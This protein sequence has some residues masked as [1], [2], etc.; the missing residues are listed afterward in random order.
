MRIELQLK[1]DD[2]VE[3]GDDSVLCLCVLDACRGGDEEG[4]EGEGEEGQNPYVVGTRS[5]GPM[6][7]APLEKP[8]WRESTPFRRA[9]ALQR[10]CFHVEHSCIVKHSFLNA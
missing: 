8:K 2:D 10:A 1:G 4:E 7:S 5:G 9:S 3:G 6:A